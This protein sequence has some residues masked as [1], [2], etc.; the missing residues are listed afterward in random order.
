MADRKNRRYELIDGRH[1]K[2]ISFSCGL[3][4]QM[5]A[6]AEYLAIR[7]M[8]PDDL[9]F[10][11]DIAFIL[12]DAASMISQWN[13][14]ELERI[15]GLKLPCILDVFDEE[16][17]QKILD[18]MVSDSGWK[19]DWDKMYAVFVGLLRKYGLP[20]HVYHENICNMGMAYKVRKFLKDN[21]YGAARNRADFRIKNF[22]RRLMQNAANAGKN[23]LCAIREGNWYYPMSLDTMKSR[24]LLEMIGDELR[25]SFR[26]PEITDEKN[27]NI[28]DVI[29]SVNSVAIHARRSDFLIYNNDC[30]RFGYFKRCVRYIKKKVQDPVWFIFSEDSEW[31]RKNLEIF[32]L[33]K[34]RDEIYFIDWNRGEESFRDMQLMSMCRHNIVTKSSFG[35]WA[36]FLNSNPDKITCSQY[37]LYDTTNKF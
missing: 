20:I 33:N 5:A 1:Y 11:E 7:K 17:R 3:G 13:G 6:Y 4:N 26:F 16:D 12:E 2:I 27:R 36:S 30:Y 25:E 32:D 22:I 14:Y 18:E 35:W 37:G 24:E 34:Y 21:I 28:M 15:F 31:C 9:Y 19:G 8:N 29:Q 10:M 23:D